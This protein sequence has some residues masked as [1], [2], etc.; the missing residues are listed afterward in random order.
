MIASITFIHN[1][2]NSNSAFACSC[3]MPAPP[4]ETLAVSDAV[5]SGRVVLVM[6]SS[7][8]YD[9]AVFSVDKTWNGVNEKI[10]FIPTASQ[11]AMCGNNFEV[12]KEYLVYASDSEG[13]LHTSSCSRIKPLAF[14]ADE[15]NMLGTDYSIPVQNLVRADNSSLPVMGIGAAIAGTV[16]FF[17]LRRRVQR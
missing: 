6:P 5:F 4:K 8:L 2:G 11:G 9:S 17:V 12:G 3:A 15:I 7:W 10:V 13:S 14:A 16:A 1:I